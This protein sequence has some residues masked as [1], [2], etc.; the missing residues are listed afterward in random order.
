MAVQVRMPVQ[1]LAA[2]T[3]IP[4]YQLWRQFRSAAVLCALLEGIGQLD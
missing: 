2:L 1:P 4:F 3:F